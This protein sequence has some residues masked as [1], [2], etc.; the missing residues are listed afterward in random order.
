MYR[1][2]LAHGHSADMVWFGTKQNKYNTKAEKSKK[3]RR[4]K[5]KRAHTQI[6]T[7]HAMHNVAESTQETEGMTDRQ[8]TWQ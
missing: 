6:G 4:K 5:K 3:K 1:K 8:Y 2:R 7:S